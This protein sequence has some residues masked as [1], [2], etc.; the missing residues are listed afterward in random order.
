MSH[1]KDLEA[2]RDEHLILQVLRFKDDGLRVTATA[3][4]EPVEFKEGMLLDVVKKAEV[5]QGPIR[6]GDSQPVPSVVKEP[7]GRPG[8]SVDDGIGFNFPKATPGVDDH[9]VA[10]GDQERY[11]R[12]RTTP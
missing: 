12:F 5:D 8:L 11:R 4:P 2:L 7:N 9:V 6:S 10:P 1:V 3:E